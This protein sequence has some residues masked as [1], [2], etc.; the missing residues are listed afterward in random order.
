QVENEDA[1]AFLEALF[2]IMH[3]FVELSFP[4]KNIQKF[5]P[6]ISEDFSDAAP[7]ALECEHSNEETPVERQGGEHEAKH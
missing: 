3:G 1:R 4:V 5:F 2:H 7:F 6:E